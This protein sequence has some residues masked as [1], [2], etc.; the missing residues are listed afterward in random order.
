MTWN[1]YNGEPATCYSD[2]DI[3]DRCGNGGFAPFGFNGILMGTATCFY[4]FI[5]FDAIATTGY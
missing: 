5:G 4:A 3:P 2:E 1:D